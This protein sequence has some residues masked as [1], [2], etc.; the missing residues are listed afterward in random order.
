MV[1]VMAWRNVWRNKMRSLVII[2]SVALGL[3]AGVMVLAIYKGMMRDRIRIVIEQEVGDLQLHHPEFKKDYDPSYVIDSAI[4]IIQKT[5]DNKN[6]KAFATRTI[7][8]GMLS[9]TTGSAGVQINGVLF[10]QE[11][12]VSQLRKKIKEGRAL[13]ANKNNDVLIG[14]KLAKK[15]KLKLGAKLVLTFTDGQSN[16]IAGAYRVAGIYESDNAPLDE[17]NVYVQKK[18]LNEMLGLHDEQFHELVI[19]LKNNSLLDSTSALLAKNFKNLK[20]ETWKVVSPET[21]LMVVTVD[22]MSYIIIGIILFALSFGIVNTM[23]MAILERTREMG[24]MMAL[25]MNKFRMF[26]LVLLETSFLT[27]VGVPIGLFISWILCSYLE[28]HGINWA[29]MGKELMSSFGFSTMIY[30][31]FPAEKIG[32]IIFFVLITALLSCIYPA[33]KALQLKPVEALRK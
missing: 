27:F 3:L 2:L 29:N 24:M 19:L 17:K 15:M 32:V 30:P 23:L 1:L 6:V 12:L 25:G 14:H 7:V 20:V 22:A 10:E 4:W 31:V 26:S 11:A 9:T 21:D 13:D 5:S 16:I 28:V 33:I 18:G 8:Q